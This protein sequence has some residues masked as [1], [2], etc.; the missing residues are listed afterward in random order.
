MSFYKPSAFALGFFIPRDFL[1]TQYMIIIFTDGAARG[2]PGPGGYG[3]VIIN[4]KE[5][6]VV[7]VGGREDRSTNNRMELKAAVEGLRFVS[8]SKEP[9][10]LY[11]D[12]KYLIN[13]ITKWIHGWRK[14][15]W[16]TKNNTDVL[17]KDLWQELAEVARE[18]IQWELLPGHSGLPGNERADEIATRYADEADPGLYHGDLMEYPRDVLN[19]KI[20]EGLV[21]KRKEKKE[22][23]N[24]SAYS[25]LSLVDGT[26]CRHK[27]WSECEARV[28]GRKARFRKT[29][30]K[31]DEVEIAEEW[32]FSPKDIKEC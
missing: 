17:N 3:A 6:T 9:I 4:K 22:R 5:G 25:Y 14:R 32:G 24:A 11:T 19:L 8:R 16:Q 18:D 21:E 2:N 20:P 1:Y 26:L 29:I 13:G 15:G 7:E 12:S 31:E 23:S 27:R 10:T 28:K 30:S